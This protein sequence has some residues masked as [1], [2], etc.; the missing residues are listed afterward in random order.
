[1]I[2]SPPKAI[3]HYRTREDNLLA[4]TSHIDASYMIAFTYPILLI[5]VCTLY[6]VLTRKIPEAFN[7]SKHIGKII[8]ITLNNEHNFNGNYSKI[9]LTV[10]PYKPP[11]SNNNTSCLG[12]IIIYF[13]RYV[14]YSIQFSGF[15]W[16][17]VIFLIV[18]SLITKERKS[19]SVVSDSLLF[20]Q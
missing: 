10:R 7:E 3:H 20:N 8:R 16:R 4:C 1:M 17:V 2:I 12:I 11:T 19:I 18:L 14:K 15:L 13:V 9:K 6:A 5:V